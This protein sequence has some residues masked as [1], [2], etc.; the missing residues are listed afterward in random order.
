V[1]TSRRTLL[2]S[3]AA[4]AAVPAAAAGADPILK[5][6]GIVSR[7]N[8]GGLISFM[9]NSVDNI[10]GLQLFVPANDA[11][12]KG[13][14]TT[15]SDRMLS[16]FNRGSDVEIAVSSGYTYRGGDFVLD[17]FFL[18]K[19]GGMHQGIHSVG[20]S[21]TDE[22]AVLLSGREVRELDINRLEASIGN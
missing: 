8:F 21:A 14:V 4:C 3:L 16:I 12:D 22:S 11:F 13:V 5:V 19:Y 6:G 2:V 17:G 1:I 18:A 7:A 10:V 9:L 15:D 20:L